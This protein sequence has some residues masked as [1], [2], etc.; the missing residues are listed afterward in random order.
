MSPEPVEMVVRVAVVTQPMAV[1]L[2]LRIKVLTAHP[3]AA[4]VLVKLVAQMQHEKV[5]MVLP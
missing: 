1:E 5:E 4:V 3:E 2:E